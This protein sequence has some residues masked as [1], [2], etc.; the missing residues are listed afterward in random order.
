MED[1]GPLWKKCYLKPCPKPTFGWDDKTFLDQPVELAKTNFLLS[2]TR[3]WVSK[4]SFW[5]PKSL[6]WAIQLVDP[7]IVLDIQSKSLFWTGFGQLFFDEEMH[8]E[9]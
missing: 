6:F 1:K 8:L 3:F 4:I 2:K 7:M 5:A 9:A